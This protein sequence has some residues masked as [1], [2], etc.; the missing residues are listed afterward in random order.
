MSSTTESTRA[1]ASTI[2]DDQ[3]DELYERLDT[4]RDLIDSACKEFCSCA[5]LV[6]WLCAGTITPQQA[7]A[8]DGGRE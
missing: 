3:L 2:T 5:E 6:Y 1:T 7:R 4:A 8:A